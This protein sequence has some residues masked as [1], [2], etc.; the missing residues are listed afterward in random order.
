MFAVDGNESYGKNC[1]LLYI[2]E[3]FVLHQKT[4]YNRLIWPD[5]KKNDAAF[6]AHKINMYN[7]MS[8]WQIFNIY[9]CAGVYACIYLRKENI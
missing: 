6:S 4:I 8:V 5:V 9:V 3:S 7:E 2:Y 1:L